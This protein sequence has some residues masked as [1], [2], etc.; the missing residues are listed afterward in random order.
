MGPPPVHHCLLWL[1]AA[2]LGAVGALAHGLLH[3]HLR[4]LL[5]CGLCWLLLVHHL[6]LLLH[7]CHWRRRGL[8]AHNLGL[9]GLGVGH[10]RWCCGLLACLLWLLVCLLWLLVCRLWW[11]CWLLV[12]LLGLLVWHWRWCCRLLVCRSWWRRG[13]GGPWRPYLRHQV[14]DSGR[15]QPLGVGLPHP[16]KPTKWANHCHLVWGGRCGWGNGHSQGAHGWGNGCSQGAHGW[17][18]G[19]SQGAHGWGGGRSQGAHGW[20]NGHSWGAHGWGG[21]GAMGGHG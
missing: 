21:A 13:G 1:V 15:A 7:A 16:A 4:L 2:H 18:N 12:C 10:W 3:L 19:R 17:G 20:G 11:C 9:L 6:W 8:L 5:V 14:P